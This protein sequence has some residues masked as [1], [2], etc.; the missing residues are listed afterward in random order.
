MPE[1][2]IVASIPFPL[3]VN[4]TPYQITTG[5]ETWSLHIERVQREHPDERIAE[6]GTNVD[7][8]VDRIGQLAYSRVTGSA[9]LE[10]D[11]RSVLGSFLGALNALIRHVRDVFGEYWIRTL[12]PADLYQIHILSPEAGAS[13]FVFGRG[14]GITRPVT[15][16]TEEGEE[17]LLRALA[18]GKAPPVWRQMHLDARDAVELGRYEDC[19]VLAWSALEAACRVALPGMA[20]RAGLTLAQF[21]TLVD[22]QKGWSRRAI[23]RLLSYEEV[24]EKTS[25]GLKIVNAAAELTQPQVYHP[26]SVTNSV[27]LAYELRNKI[28]HQGVRINNRDAW[29]VWQAVDSAFTVGLSLRDIPPPPEL[30]SWRVRFKRTQP[31]IRAFAANT[32]KRL[33]LTSPGRDDSPFRMQLLGDDLWLQFADDL[34]QPMAVALVLAYWDLWSRERR[35]MRPKLRPGHTGGLFLDGL[36]DGIASE[37]QRFVCLAESMLLVRRTH[38]AM[39]D[40][41]AYVV[42]WHVAKLASMPSIAH[43]DQ[44]WVIR[45][46]ILAAHLALLPKGGHARRL[47][48]LRTTQPHVYRAS[49]AWADAMAGLDPDNEHSSCAVL[50]RIHGGTDWLDTILVVCPSEGMAYGTRDWLLPTAPLRQ[51]HPLRD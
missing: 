28:V 22:P 6:S 39:R 25:G 27:R 40:V 21:A 5:A 4:P 2:T 15:G 45:S 44:Q 47:R 51:G 1:F 32:G 11:G 41:A 13:H 35:P 31:G 7:L 33:V 14:Q 3:R 23:S 20:H 49:A 48:P 29:E 34:T 30:L 16:L 8:L 42:D 46:T 24:L 38:A 26:D 12:E 36:V 10:E 37:V 9:S 50:R 19:V 18:D 17:R 43:D